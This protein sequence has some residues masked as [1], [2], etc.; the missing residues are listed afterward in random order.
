M[1]I[2]KLKKTIQECGVVGAG[3]AGFPTHIKIDLRANTILLNCAECEPLIN[4]DRFLL[5]NFAQEILT[6][7]K[8]LSEVLDADVI[9]AVKKT[10]KAAIDSVDKIIT[11]YPRF[12]LGLLDPVY[13]TGDE[14][15]LVYETLGIVVPPGALPI[16]IGCI[17]F[18]VETMYNIYNAVEFASPVTEK[19][20][21]IAGEV[22]NPGV[23]QILVGATISEA[24]ASAGGL[25]IENP[26]YVVNG[27][28]MG[29]TASGADKITKTTN[30]IL[31]LPQSHSYTKN[32]SFDF[33]R[34][35]SSCCQCRNCTDMCPRYLLGYPIEPHKIMRALC[36][37]DTTSDSFVGAMYCCLCGICEKFACPQSLA[38]RN[39]IGEFKT[40]FSANKINNHVGLRLASPML[41]YRKVDARRLMIR[42][43]LAKYEVPE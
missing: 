10:Y 16:D 19:W 35:A 29:K 12:R 18:N 4:V 32:I 30:A 11:G 17:V 21:T 14:V 13:P 5:A 39:L 40:A 34:A 26:A 28:M 20:V 43:G 23:K 33:K 6:A 2:G 15:M 38:P 25:L 24:V 41:P 31:V 1:T 7:L 9:I 22:K 36:Y 8:H 3:G 37:K 42:L 27:L